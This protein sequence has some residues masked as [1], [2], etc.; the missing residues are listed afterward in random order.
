[1]VTAIILTRD[2]SLHIKRCIDSLSKVCK[3]IIVVDSYSEDNT[4]EIAT[5]LGVDVF[6]NKWINYANQ[7]NWALDNCD[8][9]T[10]WVLRIDADEYFEQNLSDEIYEIL[11]NLTSE[12]TGIRIIRKDFFMG[13]PMLHGGVYPISHLK[14]FRFGFGRIENRWMDEHIIL[15]S[16]KTISCEKGNLVDD[17]KKDLTSWIQKHNGYATREMVDLLLTEYNISTDNQVNGN[18]GGNTEERKRKLKSFYIKIPLFIRPFMYF[19][20]RFIIKLGF[21][22]GKEGF[23]YILMQGFWYRMLVDCKIFELKKK[24]FYNDNELKKYLIENYKI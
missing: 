24:Y 8:I 2:E 14:L 12:I 16:G 9:K 20:Y 22:D 1:M 5:S 4:V 21:L 15:S 7:F 19:L 13:R 17:N 23:I 3:R 6:Y 11:P 10:P 18:L